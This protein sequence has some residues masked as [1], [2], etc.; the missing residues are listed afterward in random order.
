M[1]PLRFLTELIGFV[2]LVV[3][4]LAICIALGA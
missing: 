4:L 1:T 2:L 3:G